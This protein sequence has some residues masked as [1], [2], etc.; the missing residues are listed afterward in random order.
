[1]FK[2]PEQVAFHFYSLAFLN[3]HVGELVVS[4]VVIAENVS[5]LL[6]SF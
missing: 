5:T 6:R 2:S 1:M 3:R 4:A